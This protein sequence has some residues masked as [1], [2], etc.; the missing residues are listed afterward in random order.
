LSPQ[1]RKSWI[2]LFLITIV[3][4]F[5]EAVGVGLVVPFI[6]FIVSTK[7][8][9]PL[10]ITELWPQIA[11][12]SKSELVIFVTSIF[13]SFYFL[14]SL[15]ALWLTVRQTG[16]YYS[17]QETITGRLFRSYLSKDYTF[18]L[19]NNS[20]KLLSN[21]ITE[22]MQFS[23]GFTAP[24]LF[25]LNDIFIA[26]FILIVLFIVEPISALI[27]ISLFGS[28]S[29]FLF[30]VSKKKSANWGTIRQSMERLRIKSAQEGFNGI[31]DIKLSGRDDI[32]I[33]QYLKHTN[34]SLVA[35]RN[36]SIL[37]QI[38]KIF[39]EFVAVFSLCGIII[40]LYLLGDSGKVITVLG[41]FSAASFKLLPTFSRLVQS[42]QA[43][44]Y[45]KPVVSLIHE[46]LVSNKSPVKPINGSSNKRMNFERK[47]T[48][49]DLS[50]CYEGSNK[51]AI[52]NINLDLAAGK[53][54]GF[55][56]SSGAGKSTLIDCILGLI[57]LSSGSLSVDG[58]VITKGNVKEWQKNIGYVPQFIYL[59]DA[60]LRENIA[61]GISADFIDEKKLENAINKAQLSDFVSELP[62]G[63]DTFVG[64]R[65]VRLSGG[66]RQRIGIARAL[67]NDPSILVLDEATSALDIET[68]SEVMNAVESLQGSRTIIIIA[69]RFSTIKNCDYIYKLENGRVVLEG[70]PNEVL[71]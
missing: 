34:S 8:A 65:G 52:L 22:S 41:V 39:L 70:N 44:V 27:A 17:L 64:E 48:I 19:T 5:L 51:S 36:Q 50:F 62:K 23:V 31:K 57:E 33:D 67:Y 14:K 2:K 49:S 66:Q 32:F 58:E 71:G 35:G 18:H 29:V 10:F 63:L 9:L 42:C 55:I 1:Q 15:F 16:F 69:H 25:I 3:G 12:V 21:T 61:F 47:I 53:M 37:Q 59:L 30:A 24:L 46:E 6:S 11:T 13:L 7:F 26:V 43:L 40:F 54:F 68:E 45:Q 60:S 56:G 20:A 4:S 28:L 38:P